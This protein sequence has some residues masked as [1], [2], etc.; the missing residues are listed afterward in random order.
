MEKRVIIFGAGQIGRGFIGE[1]CYNS[2]YF[3]VF[4]DVVKDVVNLLN[5]EKKYPLWILGKK[6]KEKIIDNFRSIHFSN[7]EEVL[8]EIEKTDIIFTAVGAKNLLSLAPVISKGILRKFSSG[9]ERYFNII[10]CENLLGSGKLLYD[11]IIKNLPPDFKKVV[12]EKV[13]FV[14]SVVSRMVAPLTGDIKKINPLIVRVEPYNKLP[15]DKKAFKGKIPEIK[16]LY[17]VENLYPY[18][19]LKIFVHNLSH[20]CIAYLGYL[21]GYQYIWEC[22]EDDKIKNVVCGVLKEVR[23]ALIKKHGFDEREIDTY[24][25]DLLERFKN[26]LLS[27]TVYR[28]GR[29]PLRKIGPNERII[30]GIKLCLSNNIFPDNI[31]VVAAACL[32][33]NHKNDK[34]SVQLQ[35]I[36]EEKGLEFVL[37]NISK[38]DDV[39]IINKVLEYYKRMKNESSSFKEYRVDTE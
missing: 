39:R 23:E 38:V 17:P 18:E 25:S 3:L 8:S 6:K 37:K 34:E 19:E 31:C 22:L 24:I 16:G 29:E 9:E 28:V 1:I 12:D 21:K 20:A 11:E 15:V 30:G 10:I 2:G 35:E 4:V 36:V 7:K 27:D 14:E 26:K 33:Y 32:C 5:K 13:G